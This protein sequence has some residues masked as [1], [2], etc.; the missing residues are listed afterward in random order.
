LEFLKTWQILHTLLND[1]VPL[2]NDMRSQ[3]SGIIA[4]HH[5]ASRAKKT[6]VINFFEHSSGKTLLNVLRLK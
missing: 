6:E 4:H 1:R 5:A 2:L 3:L